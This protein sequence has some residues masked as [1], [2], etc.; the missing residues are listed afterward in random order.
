[1]NKN[2]NTKFDYCS[3]CRLPLVPKV[4]FKGDPAGFKEWQISGLCSDCQD[5]AFDNKQDNDNT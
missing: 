3:Y 5:E 2:K 4:E 1:M